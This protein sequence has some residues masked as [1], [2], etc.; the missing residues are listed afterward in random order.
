MDEDG[1]RLDDARSDVQRLVRSLPFDSLSTDLRPYSPRHAAAGLCSAAYPE[2][3]QSSV[4][5]TLDQGI[6][7]LSQLVKYITNKA[8]HHLNEIRP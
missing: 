8:Q 6:E 7:S 5:C 2:I 4:A 3:A 1:G